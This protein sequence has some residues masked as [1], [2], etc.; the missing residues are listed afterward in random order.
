M[1]KHNLI[2]NERYVLVLLTLVKSIVQVSE[3][4]LEINFVRITIGLF[5]RPSKDDHV[6]LQVS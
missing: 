3:R 2:K 5:Y 4:T 6:M 1:Q